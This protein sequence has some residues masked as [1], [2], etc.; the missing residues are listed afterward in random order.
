VISRLILG[1]SIG[2]F[3][4]FGHALHRWL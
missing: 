2:S 1:V 3:M 4:G